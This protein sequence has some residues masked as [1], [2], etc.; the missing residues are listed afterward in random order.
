[1]VRG[2]T[3]TVWIIVSLNRGFDIMTN[4][5]PVLRFICVNTIGVVFLKFRSI[6]MV[7]N[8]ALVRLWNNGTVIAGTVTRRFNKVILLDLNLLLDPLA[9][10]SSAKQI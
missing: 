4:I 9:C 2:D 10:I 3:I 5:G 7:S 1:M 6:V 8:E